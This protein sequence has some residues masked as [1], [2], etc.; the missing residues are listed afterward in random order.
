MMLSSVVVGL[1][2]STFMN[3]QVGILNIILQKIGLSKFAVDWL[4]DP[5]YAMFSV[6]LVIVW[7]FFGYY[8][9]IFLAAIQNIP[10]ELMEAAEI[11][12]ASEFRKLTS[13]TMPMLW[14]TIMTTVVLCISGSMR[15]FDLV[16]V[17]TQGGPANATE[18][19][20]TYMYNKT[21]SVYKYG[22]GSAVSLVI[23]LISFSLILMSQK[24]LSKKLD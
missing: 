6:C 8:M 5:K 15:S 24:L 7:Q 21:F 19:M 2:W 3:P 23:F 20:A 14:P 9:L 4:G 13:I 1:L 18:L 17:M 22:Y 16:Y 10:E 11:D 12:G